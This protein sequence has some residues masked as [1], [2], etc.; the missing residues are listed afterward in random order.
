MALLRELGYKYPVSSQGVEFGPDDEEAQ[1]YPGD[2]VEV[3]FE[4]DRDLDAI[5]VAPAI[6][7]ILKMKE[8]YPDFVLHYI[9]I[10]T[11]R[12]YVQFSAAPPEIAISGKI[13]GQIALGLAWTILIVVGAI[14]GILIAALAAA[15]HMLR[16]YAWTKPKPMGDAV[17]FCQEYDPVSGLTGVGI[18]GVDVSVDGEYKGET[19]SSGACL[20]KDLLAGI[21]L[22]GGE[23]I[24]GYE[25]PDTVKDTVIADQQI[26]VT[27]LYYT[28]PKPPTGFLTVYTYPVIGEVLIDGALH[29]PAPVGPLELARGNHVVAFGPVEGYVTP[30]NI[31]FTLQGGAWVNKTG[32]YESERQWWQT[33]LLYGSIAVAAIAGAALVLPKLIRAA[34]E[35]VRPA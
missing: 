21:H 5:N 30:P 20:V 17:I 6:S 1:M 32:I 18:A 2:I 9:R 25:V 19:D 11:R 10:E 16:G 26:E 29:G 27:I 35:K 3:W 8:Q 31:E 4:A 12:V 28:G 14:V 7:E 13:S 15:L 24:D 34:K 22:F 23:I 33:Y